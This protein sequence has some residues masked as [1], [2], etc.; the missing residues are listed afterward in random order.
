MTTHANIPTATAPDTQTSRPV[1]YVMGVDTGG[2]CTDAVLVDA[3]TRRV[4]AS[5]KRPT[6]HHDL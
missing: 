3:D 6:T 2:T 4:V 1:R 5:A